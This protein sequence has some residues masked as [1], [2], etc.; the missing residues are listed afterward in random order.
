[1]YIY[2]AHSIILYFTDCLKNTLSPFSSSSRFML[3][4]CRNEGS[5]GQHTV[6]SIH[7]CAQFGQHFGGSVENSL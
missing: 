2:P 7:V 3:V 1:M 4:S 6:I 5:T